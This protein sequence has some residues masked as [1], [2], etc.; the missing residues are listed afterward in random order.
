M[1]TLE[2]LEQNKKAKGQQRRLPAPQEE[3]EEELDRPK[4]IPLNKTK[5]LFDS[6]VTA[7]FRLEDAQTLDEGEV[8]LRYRRTR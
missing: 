3:M 5:S 1:R 4:F 8:W 7:E 6:G 2:Q